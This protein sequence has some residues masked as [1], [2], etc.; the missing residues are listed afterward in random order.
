MDRQQPVGGFDGLGRKRKTHCKHGHQFDG[1]ETWSTNWKGYSCRVCRECGKLRQ[2]RKME[3]PDFRANTSAR[4]RN[5]RKEH[6]ERYLATARRSYAKR[7]EWLRGFKAKCKYCPESRYPCLD[8]HHRDP[9]QKDVTIGQVR[10]WSRER[11][12]VEIAKCDIV[13]ANCHRWLHWEER[14]NKKGIC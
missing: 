1:T 14:H 11:L 13:C 2:R 3:N 4:M 9:A 5:W 6:S 10:H 8:F 7:D 12:T